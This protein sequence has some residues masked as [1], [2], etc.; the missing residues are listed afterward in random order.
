[1]ASVRQ[2]AVGLQVSESTIRRDL[3]ALD[4][5][6]ELVRSHG[7]AAPVPRAETAPAPDAFGGAAGRDLAAAD[8]MAVKAAELVDDGGVVLLDLGADTAMIARRL[9][10]RPVTVITGNVAVLDE[11]RDDDAVRLVL[12][13]GVLRRDSR[14]LGGSLTEHALRQ[15]GA[16]IAFLSCTGV[17]AAGVLDDVAAEVPLKRAML[18]VAARRVLIA[19]ASRFPGTGSLRVCGPA[20]I[21]TLITTTGADSRTVEAFQQAG[22]KVMAV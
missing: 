12:L 8:A 20:D 11:L 5:D 17:R 18:E 4:R 14:S 6:G 9:R 10:G 21:D 13:G 22:G 1:M 15:V 7:G 2:L 3:Q 19:S 16:D